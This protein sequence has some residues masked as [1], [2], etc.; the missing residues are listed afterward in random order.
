VVDDESI[1]TDDEIGAMNVESMAVKMK[2]VTSDWSFST[3]GDKKRKRKD[4]FEETQRS[5][6]RWAPSR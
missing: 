5:A 2:S 3:K 4:N 6:S 1:A